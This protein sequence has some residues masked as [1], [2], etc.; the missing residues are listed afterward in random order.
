VIG[1][2]SGCN[3]KKE[4]SYKKEHRKLRRDFVAFSPQRAS[5]FLEYRFAADEATYIMKSSLFNNSGVLT[6]H[7]PY[8]QLPEGVRVSLLREP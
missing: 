5:G 4:V 3:E 8:L 2:T 7:F 1:I 6:S